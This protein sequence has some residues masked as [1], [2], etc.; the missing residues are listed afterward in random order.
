MIP[1][2]LWSIMPRWAW[3]GNYICRRPECGVR[4]SYLRW[5]IPI[6]S[7]PR[8]REQRM[9][10]VRRPSA[11]W[12]VKTWRLANHTKHGI[13]VRLSLSITRQDL[14]NITQY[15]T[16][17]HSEYYSVLRGI[18]FWI[19]HSIIWN[20]CLNITHHCLGLGLNWL[21]RALHMIT[22]VSA[23]TTNTTMGFTIF[24]GPSKYL[25]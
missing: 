10:I 15:Y 16:A 5:S 21:T 1:H 4:C 2:V 19:L 7:D 20:F 25:T 9:I 24:A 6:Q 22:P 8:C 12:L 13:T 17:F 23:L 11:P 3:R 18:S 14:Q